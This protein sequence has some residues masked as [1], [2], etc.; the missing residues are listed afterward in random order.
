MFIIEPAIVSD[1][2]KIMEIIHT[3]VEQL[4]DPTWFVDDT[5]EFFAAHIEEKG[6]TLKAVPSDEKNAMSVDNQPVT[7][8]A[9]AVDRHPVTSNE[10]AAFLTVR[11][12]K[13]D[14]DNLGLSMHFDEPDL[15]KVAHME[16]AVVHPDYRGNHLERQ[17]FEKAIELLKDT[18]YCHLLGTVHPDNTASVKCFLSNGFHIE[19][20]VKKYGGLLRHIMYR[21]NF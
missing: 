3:A 9:M 16:T 7:S 4:P 18:S 17:L 12:P 13:Y 10:V 19:Q 8:N 1:V 5:K 2:D 6:F 14:K 20:T 11:F 15:L 21:K